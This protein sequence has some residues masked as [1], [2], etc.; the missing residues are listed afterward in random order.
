MGA[1][2]YASSSLESVLAT[3]LSEW[4]LVEGKNNLP[5]DVF[6]K[7]INHVCGVASYI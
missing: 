6:F 1:G 7:K 3:F 5:S 2:K 4:L